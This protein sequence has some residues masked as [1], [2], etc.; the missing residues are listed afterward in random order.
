[1][2]VNMK[3]MFRISLYYFLLPNMS[4]QISLYAS[5][6]LVARLI[7]RLPEALQESLFMIPSGFSLEAFCISMLIEPQPAFGMRK[8][9]LLDA[10]HQR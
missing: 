2:T 6:R 7:V 10:Q 4:L 1:M 8:P 3:V 9:Q 5:F